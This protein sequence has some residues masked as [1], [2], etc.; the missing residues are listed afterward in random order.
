[1]V[2]GTVVVGDSDFTTYV[3]YLSSLIIVGALIALI[4]AWRIRKRAVRVTLGILLLA[5]AS[6][7]GVLSALAMLFVAA[8]GFAAIVMAAKTPQ[9]SQHDTHEG[10][11]KPPGS[12]P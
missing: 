9:C 3:T 4:V 7:S 11:N 6:V 5:V 2:A 8:L 10:A 1:V 12:I